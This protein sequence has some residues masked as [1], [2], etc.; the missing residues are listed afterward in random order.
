MPGLPHR[1]GA[2]VACAA[3]LTVTGATAQ[4]QSQTEPLASPALQHS[5]PFDVLADLPSSDNLPSLLGAVL[6]ELIPDRLDTGGI[7]TGEAAR[8]GAHGSTWTQT[9]Y[10]LG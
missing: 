2:R 10:R 5:I 3:V 1:Y 7:S 6:P 8:L 4:G 9:Q